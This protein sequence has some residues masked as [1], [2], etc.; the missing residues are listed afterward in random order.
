MIDDDSDKKKKR[1]RKSKL[2]LHKEEKADENL[3]QKQAPA[4]AAEK[5]KYGNPSTNYF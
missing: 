3:P 2:K 1:G 5:K 4:E